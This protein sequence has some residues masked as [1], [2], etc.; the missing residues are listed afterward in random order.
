MCN[1]SKLAGANSPPSQEP[2][3]SLSRRGFIEKTL[4][5]AAL[6]GTTALPAW[7]HG[8]SGYTTGAYARGRRPIPK[9]VAHYQISTEWSAALRRL[10]PFPAARQLR[11]RR[12]ADQSGRVVP[13]LPWRAR[14]ARVVWRGPKLLILR[15]D[16]TPFRQRLA[17]ASPMAGCHV[18][19]CVG[20]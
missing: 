8:T 5:G 10:C 7:A 4:Y 15:S 14:P 1:E 13:L 2:D 18:A 9:E 16:D 20:P 12:G 17:R 6:A 19:A 3:E 11:D